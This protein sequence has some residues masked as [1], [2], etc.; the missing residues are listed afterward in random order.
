MENL[1]V[2]NR[3]R[4]VF[5]VRLLVKVFDLLLLLLLLLEL[6]LLLVMV[7]K[8]PTALEVPV[9]LLLLLQLL[10]LLLLQLLKLLLLL[11]KLLEL[12]QLLLLLLQ[13][14]LPFDHFLV[15]LRNESLAARRS[16]HL[17]PRPLKVAGGEARRPVGELEG[18]ALAGKQRPRLLHFA[19][20]KK[21]RIKFQ[22]SITR[23][24]TNSE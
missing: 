13:Q 15:V 5:E 6:L 10:L 16:L 19:D 4:L 9:E 20:L 11:L 8:A 1:L 3:L 12:L 22:D 24:A 17:T 14:L 2:A 23:V 18:L 7:T 21:A